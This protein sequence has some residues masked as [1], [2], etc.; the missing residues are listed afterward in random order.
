AQV[1][2]STGG[3][4]RLRELRHR[5]E[6]RSLQGRVAVGVGGGRAG[7]RDHDV[8]PGRRGIGRIK[9]ERGGEL[10][11][12]AAEHLTVVLRRERQRGTGGLHVIGSR[13]RGDGQQ[14]GGGGHGHGKAGNGG[15]RHQETPGSVGRRRRGSI[16][17]RVSSRWKTWW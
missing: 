15:T 12:V 5:K 2:E 11:E 4:A 13:G 6:V 14:Q 8:E 10:A 3:I 17:R 1:A 16:R 9:T 7:K